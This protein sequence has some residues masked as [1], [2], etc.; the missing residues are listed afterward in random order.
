[1]LDFTYQNG[2]KMIFGKN[3]VSQIGESVAGFG[4]KALIVYGGGSCVRSG[5][6]GRIKEQ[7]EKS[8]VQH[9]ELG[10]VKPNPRMQ[11][12]YEGIRICKENEIE[13][14]LAVGGGSVIDTAKTVGLGVCYEGDVWDFFT[15]RMAERTL[16]VGVVLTIPAAG[17]ESSRD[18]V[19]TKEEEKLKRACCG[20]D[21][22]RPVFTVMD[23]QLT[24]TLNPYQTASGSCDMIAHVLERYFTKTMAVDVTD[25]ICESLVKGIMMA[26]YKVLEEPRNYDVR[27]ELMLAGSLAHNGLAG[28]GRQEDWASHAMGHEISALTD[29]A[30]GA[31]LAV[32]FPAWMNAVYQ[33]DIRRFAQFANR[34]FE[35]PY[36]PWNEN[37]MAR[38]GI[39]RFR[40]M[41][42][43]WG[44]PSRLSELGISEKD[45]PVMAEKC[46][47]V[48]GFVR[49]NRKEIEDIYR[50]VL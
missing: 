48:G 4:R 25:R 19:M 45:I 43:D 21:F 8:G 20:A 2:T 29:A 31:T 6:L 26:T 35:V 38:A 9:W 37:A 23:P 22:I 39:R 50:S 30:H 47:Q 28:L 49:L 27:S 17:S 44:L 34:V 41:L 11:P 32:M 10:G 12:A 3:A 36:I 42:D 14:I 24:Y 13:V 33:S 40:N 16:P 5:L 15:G 1:M 7:L 18:A 46:G